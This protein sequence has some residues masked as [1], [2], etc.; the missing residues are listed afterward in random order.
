MIVAYFLGHPVGPNRSFK[1]HR[2]L[3]RFGRML[4]TTFA[5]LHI[6]W[7]RSIVNWSYNGQNFFKIRFCYSVLQVTTRKSHVTAIC[8]RLIGLHWIL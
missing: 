3:T 4:S 5:H 2:S 8:E 6:V 1:Q 7:S